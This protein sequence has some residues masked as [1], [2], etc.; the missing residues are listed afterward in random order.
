MSEANVEIIRRVWDA[1][2]RR[3]TDALFALFDPAI[4][5]DLRTV[6]GPLAG[7]YYGHEGVRQYFRAWLDS[8]ETHNTEAETF[9]DAAGNV[10]AGIRLSGRGKTSGVE[11]EMSR[12][13]V[14]RIR[15]GLVIHV[16]FFETKAEALEAA[17]QQE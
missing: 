17:G 4:V 3:D 8:F 14:H 2:E 11:V 6:P 15:K 9:I 10:V 1:A 5:W 16:E 12:W 13:G 7:V